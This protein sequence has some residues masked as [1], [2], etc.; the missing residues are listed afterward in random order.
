MT[1]YRDENET[2]RAENARLKAE[3]EGRPRKK[4]PAILLAVAT[5]IAFFFLMP[6]LNGSD[7]RFWSAIAIIAVLAGATLFAAIRQT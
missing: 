2:L 6:W 7:A 5:S 1:P 3:L 4:L